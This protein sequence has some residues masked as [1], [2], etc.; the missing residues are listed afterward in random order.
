M[1]SLVMVAKAAEL[2]IPAVGPGPV[3]RRGLGKAEVRRSFITTPVRE[4][5]P[6]SHHKGAT[7]SRG[8]NW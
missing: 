7:G 8:S 3:A 5:R 1:T 4:Q 6:R 2:K